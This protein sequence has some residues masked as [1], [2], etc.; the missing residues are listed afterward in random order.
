MPVHKN[1][2]GNESQDL[3]L[4][5]L[6]CAVIQSVHEFNRE[7]GLK[8][9]DSVRGVFFE[10]NELYPGAG[11]MEKNHIQICVINPNCIKGYFKPMIP[12]EGYSV[13]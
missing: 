12:L 5:F 13:P 10:G 9:Y 11:F 7:M 1:G 2:R 6:D 8:Q 3:L 4:R